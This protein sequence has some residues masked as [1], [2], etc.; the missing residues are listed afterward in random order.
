VRPIMVQGCTSDAG[1]SFLATALCRIASDRGIRVAPFKAQNM[2][3][4][5]AVC[6]DGGEIGRAQWLQARAARVEP[7]TRMNPVLLKPTADTHSH[8]IVRG[9]TDERISA[10]PFLERPPHLWQHVRDALD[11][12]TSEHELVIAEGA[13][14]PAEVNLR[15]RDI[16]NMSIAL[17]ARADVYIASDIDRGGSFAHLLGTYL[18][19][20][21]EERALVRGFVLNR[22]RGD[23][24]LLGDAPSWL[25]E[26]TGVPVVAVV[27]YLAHRLPEEDTLHHRARPV[28]G[29]VNIALLAYPYASNLDEFDPLVHEDG[30]TVTPIRDR[31]PLAGYDAVILPG[32]R[33]TAA[34]MR[35]LAATGLAAEVIAFARSRKP[36]LGVCGGLQMLGRVV[37]DPHGIEG[38]DQ[39]GLGLLD[40]ETVLERDKVTRRRETTD[41]AWNVGAR[42]RGYEIHHGR[43]RAGSGATVALEDDLGWR[44]GNVAGVVLHGLAEDTAWRGAFLAALGWRG[45]ARDWSAE[46]DREIDRVAAHV[47]RAFDVAEIFGRD[48]RG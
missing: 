45:T 10:M 34:S 21:A 22:F 2:S 17:H 42:V 35:H 33:N 16:V 27:P 6:A 7:D 26:R 36:V 4:N 46:L 20:A 25:S 24:T 18:C 41:R 44:Q 38:G 5:A 37:R 3:N 11:S 32:S 39:D 28:R 12:L 48:R 9:R 29:H 8:V 43:T 30:V 47:A 14:S 23:P 1:K 13:G 19:L 40:V 15:S 31:E